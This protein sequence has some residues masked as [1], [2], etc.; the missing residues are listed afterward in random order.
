M[1]R[2]IYLQIILII[3][4]LSQSRLL[5]Q[6][7]PNWRGPTR[8]GKTSSADWNPAALNSKESIKWTTDV[9]HGF[10][11]VV[12]VENHIFAYGSTDSTTDAVVCL[13]VDTGHQ[14]WQMT[15]DCP[16]PNGC[17]TCYK[18]PRSTPAFSEGCLYALSHQGHLLCL[19]AETGNIIWRKHLVDDFDAERPK[20]GFSGSPV[21]EDD[22]L[23]LNA[24]ES[25]LVLNKKTG[26]KIWDTPKGKASFSTPVVFDYRNKKTI[27]LFA[28]K[29]LVCRD[30]KSGKEHWTHP[31]PYV[32]N[33]GA[34]EVD[35]V[36]V[37][38]RVFI[39]SGYRKGGAVIDFSSG[40][41]KELWFDPEIRTEFG[42]ALYHDGLLFAP[43]GDTRR[44]TSYLKCIDF[45]TGKVYWTRDTGHCSVI[46][47]DDKLMVLNQWGLLRI[48]RADA[49]GYDDI[50]S[51]EVIE[52][53]R[54]KRCWTAPIFA[55]GCTFIKRWDGQL[56]CIDLNHTNKEGVQ[57]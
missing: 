41:P 51:A 13:N 31:W 19:N 33:D 52:T 49:G 14:V 7:W 10:G 23:I 57:P 45:N 1:T 26:Q 43:H 16:V 28:R 55:Y 37:D 39:S 34:A 12:V 48:M 32:N 47:I 4:I 36:V 2:T 18:G 11:G 21:I 29:K 53:S 44:I 24:R 30:L 38:E 25:G 3:A 6:D 42:T 22:Y 40:K 35:P 5:A 17:F 50:S 20:Y 54:D 56:V 27:M 9:G 8:D 46:Q 15:F